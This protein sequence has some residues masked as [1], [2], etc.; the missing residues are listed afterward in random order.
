VSRSQPITDQYV[1]DVIS[2]LTRVS[3]MAESGGRSDIFKLSRDWLSVQEVV[4]AVG[5]TSCGAISVFIGS[6]LFII[7]YCLIYFIKLE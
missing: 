7:K 4:D 3:Q 5:S 2:S 6:D 1:C